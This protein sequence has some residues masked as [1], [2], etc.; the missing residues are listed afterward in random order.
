MVRLPLS[1]LSPIAS[2]PMRSLSL[3]ALKRLSSFRV[4]NISSSGSVDLA[5]ERIDPENVNPGSGD[6]TKGPLVIVHGLL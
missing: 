1:S 6:D 3:P 2:S 5:Y 4:R